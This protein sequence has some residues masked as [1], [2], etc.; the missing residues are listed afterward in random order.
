M[1]QALN[2][3]RKYSDL[4][5]WIYSWRQ[6]DGY[7]GFLHHAIHGTVNWSHARLVP[8]YTY[9][10]LMSGFMNLYEKTQNQKWLDYALQTANDLINIL[11]K[12]NQF[13]Y[14][15]FEFAPAGGSIVHTINPLFAFF[16]LYRI[17]GNKKLLQVSKAVLES[18]VCIYWRGSNLAG[19]FNMTLMAT[20]AMAEYGELTGDWRLYNN[21][22]KPCFELAKEHRVGSDEKDLEGLYYR[23]EKDHSIIFPWYNCV[24]ADAMMRV[25]KATNNSY[26]K[27]EGISILNKVKSLMTQDYRLPHSYLYEK[28]KHT[29]T[30]EPILIAPA[31]YSLMLMQKHHLLTESEVQNSIDSLISNQVSIG[32]IRPN[33]GYDWRSYTGI[34]AWN[35][36]VFEYF[37]QNYTIN[38]EP[39]KYI[40][41]Y[42]VTIGD[43]TVNESCDF[44]KLSYKKNPFIRI[45]KRT[46]TI[47]QLKVTEPNSSFKISPKLLKYNP[48]LIKI[49]RQ[50]HLGVS[51][52]DQSGNGI[53]LSNCKKGNLGIWS[54]S[55]KL[56]IE[57]ENENSIRV[58]GKRN[59]EK[60]APIIYRLGK[61]FLYNK[62]F[63]I[64]FLIR[65]INKR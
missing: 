44:F 22:G 27:E 6:A 36:F 26:W 63:N 33:D 53:W 40:N 54:P 7:G 4:W 17:T 41:H 47:K 56:I 59:Y 43:V 15:G 62:R 51:Y 39:S 31:A 30:T 14:S 25:A 46:G 32:Y 20:A 28:R 48:H 52:I 64:S 35:A 60:Y 11:D 10:P 58:I 34:M 65:C 19:P 45:E 38:P 24:K 57:G 8:S 55:H 23:L 50:R 3:K 21:Y 42:D 18:V 1:E 12:A 49:N 61:H 5:S 2:N 37:S 13:K 29:L 9:Q 16:R